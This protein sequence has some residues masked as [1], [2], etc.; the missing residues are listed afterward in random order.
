MK[1]LRR[2]FLRFLPLAAIFWSVSPASGSDNQTAVLSKFRLMRHAE[3]PSSTGEDKSVKVTPAIRL[4]EAFFADLADPATDLRI[5]DAAGNHL[6]FRLNRISSGGTFRQESIVP[7]KIVRNQQLPDGRNVVDFELERAADNISAVELSGL[8]LGAAPTISIAA[9]SEEKFQTLI[10]KQ[11]LSDI[12]VIQ[13]MPLRRFP[14]PGCGAVKILRLTLV[15]GK[16]SQL[17]TLRVYA[18]EKREHPD[19][20]L[21]IPYKI[22]PIASN[23]TVDGNNF[24]YAIGN[25]PLT[26]LKITADLPLYQ[27]KAEVFSSNDRRQWQLIGSA[28]I[29]Q[30]DLDKADTVDFPE[31]RAQYIL[32]KIDRP[33]GRG[34]VKKISVQ[35]N[36]PAYEWLLPESNDPVH[37]VTV[38]YSANL[39]MRFP[40]PADTLTAPA[41]SVEKKFL[42]LSTPTDNILH[43]RGV[44]DRSAQRHLSGALL[45]VLAAVTAIYTLLA[46]K[47]SKKL[48]PED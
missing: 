29:R 17:E 46:G 23:S 37:A 25:L 18:S 15:N 16:F 45:T 9:E 40:D 7:G 2:G 5:V 20:P 26:Q 44:R 3:F 19:V 42:Q 39:Q 1:F 35:A 6:P 34:P 14:L 21:Q 33:Q 31:T 36:G 43:P 30:V 10:D 4:D 41:A 11:P 28:E 22:T 32:I 27:R 47:R 48:L 38:Y 8:D 24:I 12:S 13:D